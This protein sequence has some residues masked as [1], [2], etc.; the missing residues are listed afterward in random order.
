MERTTLRQTIGQS[1]EEGRPAPPPPAFKQGV[2][3]D[4]F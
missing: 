4:L 3:D 1:L 2:E